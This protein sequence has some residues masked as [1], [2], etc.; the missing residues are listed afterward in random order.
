[1]ETCQSEIG[2]NEFSSVKRC[3]ELLFRLNPGKWAAKLSKTP[4]KTAEAV[5]SLLGGSVYA[6]ELT[7]ESVL[8]EHEDLSIDDDSCP[9]PSVRRVLFGSP[10]QTVNHFDRNVFRLQINF[11][12]YLPHDGLTFADPRF[13]DTSSRGDCSGSWSGGIDTGC[14][15]EESWTLGDTTSGKCLLKKGEF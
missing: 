15:W 3:I 2:R 7:V 13:V 9:L 5:A 6:E 12:Q 14:L 4:E 10:V 8:K 11:Y 1:M